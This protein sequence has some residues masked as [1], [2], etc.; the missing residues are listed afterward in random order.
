[1]EKTPKKEA[2]KVQYNQN[3]NQSP[4]FEAFEF[5]GNASEFFKIWII[6]VTLTLI[7]LGIYSAWAKVRTNRYIY[8]NTYLH[9]SNFEYNA[10]PKRILLGRT[11]IVGFY[12]LF[13]LFSDYLGIYWVSAAIAL[14]F[15][16]LLPWLMRQAISFRLKNTS[17]RNI[18]FF[19]GAKGRSFYFFILKAIVVFLVV[20]AIFA[21]LA[22]FSNHTLRALVSLFYIISLTVGATLF[23]R[24]FKALI[25]DNAWYGK[26]HF[27][28]RATKKEAFKLFGKIAL[29]TLLIS[30]I[31]GVVGIAISGMLHGVKLHNIKSLTNTQ[32][33]TIF[34]TFIGTLVYLINIGLYK[35]SLDAL[36][37]NF[38][39]NHTTIKEARFKGNIH[40]LKLA[41]ISASNSLLLL[42][43]LGLLYPYT[44]LRYLKYKITHSYFACSSYDS[45]ISDGYKQSSA[46]GDAALD[47]FDIDI[48]F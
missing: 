39:R 32:S 20:T 25:I 16:L 34:L 26:S 13:L 28:F 47:F 14:I 19:F 33:G 15:I 8:S 30:L 35:G 9:G 11:I 38:T 22:H 36:L 40:P 45:F 41:W 5:R 43:S 17:Y 31:L 2:I 1:M 21:I 6:N 10:N 42:F 37:S 23:Y 46:I 24:K 7:T 18:P 12:M 3:L 29:W 4:N 44:K 48:G 27:Q